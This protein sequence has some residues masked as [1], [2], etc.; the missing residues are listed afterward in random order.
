MAQEVAERRH[1]WSSLRAEYLR[2]MD[3]VEVLE[4]TLRQQTAIELEQK[5]VCDRLE[6]ECAELKQQISGEFSR[7]LSSMDR[8]IGLLRTLNEE[9][10]KHH[11]ELLK[12]HAELLQMDRLAKSINEERRELCHL[13]EAL[14]YDG[15]LLG[16]LQ[17]GDEKSRRR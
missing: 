17:P 15:K 7:D 12:R 8:L 5:G 10:D 13:G 4:D 1:I 2:R 14:I 3:A 11:A 9:Q 16:M 6:K